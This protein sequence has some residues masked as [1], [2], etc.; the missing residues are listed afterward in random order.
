METN[1]RKNGLQAK[2]ENII[3][4]LDTYKVLLHF[5]NRKDPLVIH[6]DKPARRFYFSLIAL[7]VTEMKN[8]DKSEF[9]HIRKHE[10]TLKLL[11]NSLAGPNASKT[12]KGMWEKIRKAWR[13]RLP[14]LETAVFFKVVDRNLISPY[15]KGG[16]YRYDCSDDE[17]DIWANLFGYDEN[18]P[19]RFKFAIDSASLSLNDISVTLGDLRDNPAL[20]E[21]LN[22]MRI[23]PKV[24]SR[25]KQTVPRWWKKPAFSLVAVLI[26]VAVIAVIWNSYMR[27]V[28][29]TTETKLSDKPSIAVLPFENMSDDPKQEYFTDGITDDLITDLSKISGLFVIARNSAFTYKGKPVK[30]QQ[31]ARELGV[32]YVLEGSVRKAGDQLRINAQLINATTGH[33]LWAER[34]DGKLDDIF[35]L[36]DE[37]TQKIVSALAVRLTTGDQSL[38]AKR[39]TQ[40]VQAYDAFLQ[41]S[42]HYERM[43]PGD[44]VKAA[45]YYKKAIELDP[46][47]G[48]AHAA[49]AM[50]YGTMVNRGW[51]EKL[52][53]TNAHALS[54]EHLETAMRNPT[55]TAYRAAAK[56][57][58]WQR[59]FEEAIVAAERSLALEPNSTHSHYHMA[60]ILIYAG[61]SEEAVD[62]INM[63]MRLD[64]QYPAYY[65]RHLGLARL[66]MGQMEEAVT[67]F[68]RALQRNP[69]S[70][71]TA[72][73]V[74]YAYLGREQEAKDMLTK[75]SKRRGI[76]NLSVEK[77]MRYY[78]FKDPK[79]ANLITEGLREAG[80]K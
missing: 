42:D 10:K 5:Q 41:G 48:R 43:T 61:K 25:E 33:H 38:L 78:P 63:A 14:G 49:L 79:D 27:S 65:L 45:S 51:A 17:C 19:W 72:L 11:D 73:A 70:P 15:E 6:F 31:I 57:L 13:H 62:H 37:F 56:S 12:V 8:L 7:V 9:I 24:V 18:N 74:T 46:N 39:E 68:E 76:K 77:V 30:A 3:L 55:A 58:L 69:E 34:F 23:Q 54:K 71:I 75:F 67:L 2:L 60:R 50:L 16:K 64:P 1:S 36:Q 22:R 20:K 59:K 80:L 52:G 26:V 32:R 4:D 29:P 40:N 21:F 66:C 44:L 35:N 28:S 47:Y 53:W